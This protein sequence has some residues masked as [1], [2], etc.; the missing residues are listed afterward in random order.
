MR[1]PKLA[2]LAGAAVALVTGVD[3]VREKL[4]G[5]ALEEAGPSDDPEEEDVAE[6]GDEGWPWPDAAAVE[7]W[8]GR[9]RGD[10]VAG[11]RYVGGRIV[12]FEGVAEVLRAGIQPA[13]AAAAVERCVLK[14]RQG[15]FEVRARGDRQRAELG[16]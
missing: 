3:L 12:D 14:P 7:R 2:R 15:L 11:K 1:S 10:F 5:P 6:D 8:W 16:A 13:R 4:D 9:R